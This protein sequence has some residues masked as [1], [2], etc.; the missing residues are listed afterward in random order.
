MT[1]KAESRDIAL[2]DDRVAQPMDMLTE[3]D[4]EALAAIEL[5]E[6]RV[7]TPKE[8]AA[9]EKEITD[10]L[11]CRAENAGLMALFSG[12]FGMPLLLVLCAALRFANLE[13]GL[14]IL[15]MNLLA[16]SPAAIFALVRGGER[17]VMS[18]IAGRA[19]EP[20]KW[21]RLAKAVCGVLG[22]VTGWGV[23][24]AM[25]VQAWWAAIPLG[26]LSYYLT[27]VC[28]GAPEKPLMFKRELLRIE[29][30][31]E[32]HKLQAEA[33]KL[34]AEEQAILASIPPLP[35]GASET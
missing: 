34:Q 27:V 9:R 19:C 10:Y 22:G 18:M 32:Q 21:R 6:E 14:V 33:A 30:E 25:F 26:F 11:E 29:H 12:F 5:P 8:L 23:L 17:E 2:I 1:K 20:S 3:T 28:A 24:V 15:V 35:D 16:L 7:L 31:M 4:W 13:E